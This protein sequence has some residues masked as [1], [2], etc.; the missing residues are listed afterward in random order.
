MVR[1]MAIAVLLA[2]PGIGV[3]SV[4]KPFGLGEGALLAGLMLAFVIPLCWL[5]FKR[6]SVPP[7]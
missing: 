1:R 4:A 6:P 7:E 2:L 3:A 5:A